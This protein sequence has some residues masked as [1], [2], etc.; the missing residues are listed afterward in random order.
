MTSAL[1]W[2][3]ET[4]AA[5][6]TAFLETRGLGSIYGKALRHAPSDFANPEFRELPRHTASR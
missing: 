5:D 6:S 4:E 2:A 1:S 3:D